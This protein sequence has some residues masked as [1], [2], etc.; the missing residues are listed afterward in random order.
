MTEKNFDELEVG[1]W[2]LNRRGTIV[3]IEMQFGGSYI[4][5]NSRDYPSGGQYF[6]RNHPFDLITKIHPPVIVPFKRKKK[7][8]LYLN[9][10]EGESGKYY[11]YGSEEKDFA[12]DG[13]YIAVAVPVTVE[14]DE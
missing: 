7:I 12:A 2:Y 10:A 4:D 11:S 6:H 9:I 13:Y 8:T 1:C 14:V 5:N 3:S